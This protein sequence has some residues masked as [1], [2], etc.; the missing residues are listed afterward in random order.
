[1]HY[2]A[3]SVVHN[4]PI[5]RLQLYTRHSIYKQDGVLSERSEAGN[6]KFAPKV[7]VKICIKCIVYV[8]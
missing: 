5:N 8:A 3:F 7:N 2:G 1:M 6:Y 4:L